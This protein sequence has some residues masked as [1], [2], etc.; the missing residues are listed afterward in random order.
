MAVVKRSET[1]PETIANGRNRYLAY[2]D[3]LMVTVIDF[4]DG[5]SAQPDPPH[6]H[7]HE[8]VTYCAEGEVLF[9]I[10][11]EPHH[12]RPGDLITV[13]SNAPHSIQLL[14]AQ[15]RL[16]DSFTP[17]RDDFLK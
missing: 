10:N 16:V 13:P 6:Q 2:T 17:I 4:T 3:S 11:G 8:Q 14:S 7:P 5:P 1:T 9:F 12:L 15:V